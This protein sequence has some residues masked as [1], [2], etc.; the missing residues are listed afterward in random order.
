MATLPTTLEPTKNTV[1]RVAREMN[2]KVTIVDSLVEGAFGIDQ[3]TFLNMMAEYAGKI[4][5]QVD[6][7]VFAQ[8]SMAYAEP[9]LSEK[10][11]KPMLGSPR[12]G[13]VALRKALEMKGIIKA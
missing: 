5:D 2:K 11:G 9:V 1:K 3:E 4:I 10:Y 13:A 6:V 8:G 7:I 12:F